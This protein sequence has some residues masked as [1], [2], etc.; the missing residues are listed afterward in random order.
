LVRTPLLRSVQ[1]LARD[2]RLATERNVSLQTVSDWRAEAGERRAGEERSG[3]GLSRREFLI[4]AGAGAVAGALALPRMARADR[5]PTIA[6]IGGGIAGLSCAL[7]L[8]DKGLVATVYEASDRIGGRMHSNVRYFDEGQTSEWCGELIDT[9]HLTIRN[10]AQRFR[11]DVVDVKAAEPNGSEDTF[12]FSNQYYPR[13]VAN[14]DFRPVHKVLQKALHEA[15]Y[16]TT[17]RQSTPAGRALDNTSLYDWIEDNIPGGHGSPMGMLLDVAYTEELAVSTKK[18]SSLNLIYLL[19]FEAT[20]GNFEI[21]GISD[22]RSHIAGGNQLLPQ[23]IAD[24]LGVGSTVLTGWRLDAIALTP[25]GRYS[26]DFTVGGAGR[27]VVAD[28]A[29]LCIPFSVLRTLDYSKAGFDELKDLDIQTLGAG[30][31]GKL[32]LQFTD[33]LWNGLGPWPG[34]SDGNSYSDTGY[35]N[36]WD[37]TRAQ[38]GRSGILVDY[39]GG[40]PAEAMSTNVAYAFADTPSVVADAQGFLARIEPVFPGL[41]ARWNGKAAI[42]LP[43]LD[44]NLLL[45]YSHWEIG[46]YQTISGYEGVRQGNLRRRAHLD[47]LPGIHGGRGRLRPAGSQ[48]DPRRPEVAFS[49]AGRLRIRTALAPRIASFCSAAKTG[50]SMTSSTVWSRSYQGKSVPSITRSWPMSRII[51]ASCS[52]V[53]AFGAP[54]HSTISH[55]SNTSEGK[56]FASSTVWRH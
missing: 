52:A 39:T 7:R 13:S 53:G 42:S 17:Y 14:R 44:P 51:S 11:L 23:A 55:R 29:V 43:H 38:V 31:S 22:E 25:G 18:Q 10:L 5:R 9:N 2:H 4:G 26:L 36:T 35:Q 47:R 20:P 32:Q 28:Y 48:R 49:Q 6:I 50:R 19:G 27:N 24:H 33:R 12:Y 46:Q 41:T 56:A 54:V 30:K 21:F 1:R 3:K 37:V 15:G 8:A 16:P 40:P 45:S 34:V